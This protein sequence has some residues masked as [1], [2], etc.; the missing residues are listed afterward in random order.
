MKTTE[1]VTALHVRFV[2][3]FDPSDDCGIFT[4]KAADEHDNPVGPDLGEMFTSL[5]VYGEKD[6]LYDVIRDASWNQYEDRVASD[7][8]ERQYRHEAERSIA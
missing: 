7:R 4:I 8:A 3:E 5:K 1:I 2:T 6:T